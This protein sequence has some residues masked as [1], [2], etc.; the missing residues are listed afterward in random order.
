MLKEPISGWRV[1]MSDY[2]NFLCN[3]YITF[4]H[5]LHFPPYKSKF[6]DKKIFFISWEKFDRKY[7]W[8]GDRELNDYCS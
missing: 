8:V 3:F 4:L 2:Y 5:F 1:F 6:Y 7:F